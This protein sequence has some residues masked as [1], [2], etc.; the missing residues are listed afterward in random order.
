MP[1]GHRLSLGPVIAVWVELQA[2][3][4]LHA[5]CVDVRQLPALHLPTLTQH[6]VAAPLHHAGAPPHAHKII[7]TITTNSEMFC[8]ANRAE[9]HRVLFSS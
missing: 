8:L 7:F 3:R 5:G 6:Q 1:Q 2:D 4:L 9:A